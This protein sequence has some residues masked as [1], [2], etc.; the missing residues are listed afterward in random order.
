MRLAHLAVDLRLCDHC[1][2]GIQNDH[3]QCARTNQRLHDLKRLLAGVRLGHKQR[4]NID[5]QR[6][7]VNGIERVL[8]VDK[9]SLAPG[10]LRLRDDLQCD[11]RLTGGFRTVYL[12][13]TTARNAANTQR[14]IETERTG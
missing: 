13:D 14:H 2:D 11:R 10:F 4:I 5:T 3:V 9:R 12:N 6:L 7:C 1:R 8:N